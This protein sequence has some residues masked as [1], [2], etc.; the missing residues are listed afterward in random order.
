MTN[1]A[2]LYE[3]GTGQLSK[4]LLKSEQYYTKACERAFPRALNNFGKMLLQSRDCQFSTVKSSHE[5]KAVE[6]FLKAHEQGY[7]KGTFNLG[8]CYERGYYYARDIEK[9]KGMFKLAAE[10]GDADAKM[11][12]GSYLLKDAVAAGS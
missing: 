7:T 12:Y 9:A 2:G 11:F 10:K 5:V 1:L 6:C 8:I 3:H 4:D